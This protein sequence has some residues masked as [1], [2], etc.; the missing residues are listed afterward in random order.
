M[1]CNFFCWNKFENEVPLRPKFAVRLFY[2]CLKHA[3]SCFCSFFSPLKYPPENSIELNVLFWFSSWSLFSGCFFKFIRKLWC[4]NHWMVHKKTWNACHWI[5]W[6]LEILP[7]TSYG[8]GKAARF[9][10]LRKNCHYFFSTVGSLPQQF[11]C[12]GLFGWNVKDFFRESPTVLVQ[13]YR[14]RY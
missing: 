12:W 6:A 1:F 5:Y 8:H 9:N 10:G 2:F 13:T 3:C 11:V 14:K 7:W 4:N